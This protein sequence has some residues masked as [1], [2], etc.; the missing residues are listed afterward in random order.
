VGVAGGGFVALDYAA[1]HPDRL[2]NLV[3][4]AST[5]S[6]SEREIQDFVARIEIPGI[7][8]LSA[9]YREV[10]A[11]YRGANPE[12]TKRWLE[13]E[14][15]ARQPNAPEQPPRSPNTY[16]K[17]RGIAT[18]TLVIAP[19]ADLLAPPALMQLWARQIKNA[20]WVT[21]PDAGHAVA[22]ERPGVFNDIVLRFLKGGR[23]FPNVP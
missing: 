14:H 20:Q 19:D 23:P 1:W 4:G 17:L 9:H 21:V 6:V 16:A 15:A 7:R 13:I 12:G 8:S 11:S 3:V 18:R 2:S 10:S 22:W 5:G